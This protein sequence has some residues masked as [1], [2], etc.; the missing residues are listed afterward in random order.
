MFPFTGDDGAREFYRCLVLHHLGR[1]APRSAR[2][3]TG[4]RRL[5][6]T[7][8]PVSSTSSFRRYRLEV[9]VKRRGLRPGVSTW[10]HREIPRV[11]VRHKPT[12][13]VGNLLPTLPFDRLQEFRHGP[14][15]AA[16][17][18]P[19]RCC[20]LGNRWLPDYPASAVVRKRHQPPAHPARPTARGAP[21]SFEVLAVR[22]GSR[23]ALFRFQQPSPFPVPRGR[24]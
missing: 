12:T 5:E 14:A 24:A 3:R 21:V 8:S 1:R 4:G 6:P 9:R 2:Q 15:T 17:H 7:R 22:S 10:A 18:V 16:R 13:P 11:R 20:A 23:T 19:A